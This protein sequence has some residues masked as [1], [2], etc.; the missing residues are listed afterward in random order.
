MMTATFD[1]KADTIGATTV[2]NQR[3]HWMGR[4]LAALNRAL[5]S[6]AD[7]MRGV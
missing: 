6:S 1:A 4:F 2:T 5:E 3:S 7:G